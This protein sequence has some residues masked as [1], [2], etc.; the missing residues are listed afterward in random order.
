MI[1][2]RIRPCEV[3]GQ[4]CLFHSFIEEELGVLQINDN[5]VLG[6]NQVERLIRDFEERGI[7]AHCCSLEKLRHAWALVEFPD[8]SVKKVE[9]EKVRFLDREESW[10]HE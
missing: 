5:I 6:V 7:V 1:F 3:D 9:P 8:G 10:S 2:D 4:L